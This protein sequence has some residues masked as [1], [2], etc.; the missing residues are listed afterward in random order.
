MKMSLTRLLNEI[1]L[2]ES[3]V[4]KLLQTSKFVTLSNSSNKK[5]VEDSAKADFNAINDLL[6]RKAML[7][8]LLLEANNKTTLVVGG[9]TYTIVEALDYKNAIKF[10]QGLVKRLS[11]DL[12]MATESMEKQNQQV[13]ININT[14]I[15][16]LV[17]KDRKV[18]QE[19]VD[20]IAT[21]YREKH[22]VSLVDPVGARNKIKKLEEEITTFLNEVDF[23]L[24]EV[25]AITQVEIPT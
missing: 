10:K 12:S 13:E 1:K 11:H 5:E 19:E 17:G 4:E 9:V 6:S 22:T 20:A 8:K 14:I 24:S 25:N 2:V 7:K 18:S 23:C 16:T 21:P 3:K 15:T